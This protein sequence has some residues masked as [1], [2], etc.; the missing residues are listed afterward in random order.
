MLAIIKSGKVIATHTDDQ[1]LTIHFATGGAYEGATLV[2][3][4]D[5]SSVQP[6]DDDPRTGMAN[7]V[8]ISGI[9]LLRNNR[10]Q[11]SDW[12]Q[13]SDTPLASGIQADWVTY[14]QELRDFPV[15]VSN[16]QNPTWPT[17]P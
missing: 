8:A 12:T 17:A 16:P 11:D 2:G 4:L 1:D 3:L 6:G 10:L 13:I 5:D 9:R 7:D 15:D 14:R